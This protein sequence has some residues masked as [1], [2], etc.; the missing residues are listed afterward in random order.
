MA[1]LS[2]ARKWFLHTA[3]SYLGTPYIWGGDD[4]SGFDCSGFVIECLKSC[5]LVGEYDDYSADGLFRKF[6]PQEIE[7][8]EEAALLFYVGG[9]GKMVHVTICLDHQ[10]QIGASG[11]ASTISNRQRAWQENAFVKIRPIRFK[12]TRMKVLR[13]FWE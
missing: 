3:L 13:T 10:F 8:P 4:P 1:G 2:K 7:T 12:P 9:G 6:A 11:G 5:G